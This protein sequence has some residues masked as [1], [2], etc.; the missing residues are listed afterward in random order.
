V[1]TLA[2]FHLDWTPLIIAGCVAMAIAVFTT[3]RGVCG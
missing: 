1:T 2:A 3:A